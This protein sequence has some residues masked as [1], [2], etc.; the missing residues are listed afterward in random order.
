MQPGDAGTFDVIVETRSGRSLAG[1]DVDVTCDG[2]TKNAGATQEAEFK[3]ACTSAPTSFSLGL[4]MFDV[5]PHDIS[6]ADRAGSGNIYV[7]EFDP[8]DMGRKP[9]AGHRLRP[10]GS[11][12]L[13]MIYD[14][15]PILELNGRTF[16]YVRSR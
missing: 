8:A 4:R 1:I 2:T 14:R 9:F 3:I 6:V 16:R 5:A 10:D 7:F 15:S 12:A 11:D 13:A